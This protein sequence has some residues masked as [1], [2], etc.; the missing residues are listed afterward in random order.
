MERRTLPALLA[1]LATLVTALMAAGIFAA[2]ASLAATLDP[3]LVNE[4]INDGGLYV[5][6]GAKYFADDAGKDRLR[7]QLETARRPVYVAVVPTGTSLTPTGLY[8]IVKRKGTY[9]VLNGDTLRASSN[10]LPSTQVKA[11][12]TGATKSS[13]GNPANAVVSFVRLTN[14]VPKNSAIGTGTAPQAGVPSAAAEPSDTAT[15][16]AGTPVSATP[17][18]KDGGLSP[19]VIG[20]IAAVLL[21]IATGGLLVWRSS[22]KKGQRSGYDPGPGPGYGPGPGPGP[23]Y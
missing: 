9:A 2:P 8:Q 16:D 6:S 1:S 5:D 23:G 11:A 13:A 3:E 15:V 18:A 4:S 10:V 22:R 17:P 20:G 7:A 21:A 19:L 12:L 14:G